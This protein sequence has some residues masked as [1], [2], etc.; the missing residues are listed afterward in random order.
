MPKLKKI[1]QRTPDLITDRQFRKDA[2]NRAANIVGVQTRKILHQAK[3]IIS[4][5]DLYTSKTISK[6]DRLINLHKFEAADKLLIEAIARYP[7]KDRVT[8]KTLFAWLA[9][10]HKRSLI[11]IKKRLDRTNEY[12][13]EITRYKES[14]NKRP[15]NSL[16]IALVTAI[17]GGYDSVKLPEIV[18]P[19]IDYYLFTD[20]TVRDV[21]VFK[22]R[23]LP[24]IDGDQTRT[25]RY[26]K[27]NA[28]R[29]L[30]E[31]DLIVWID[32]NIMILGDIY[33]FINRVI[34]NKCG[35]GG[36]RHPLRNNL[37]DEGKA[38]IKAKRG[39]IGAIKDQLEFYRSINYNSN[40]LLETGFMIYDTRQTAVRE[41]LNMW[42][43][44]IDTKSK[45]DQISVNYS[46]DKSEVKWCSV[47]ERPVTIRNHPAF[48]LTRHGINAAHHLLESNLEGNQ[49]NPV[50]TESYAQTKNEPIKGVSVDIIYCVYN[51]LDDVKICLTSVKKYIEPNQRLIIIDDGSDTATK[52]YLVRFVQKNKQWC[53]LNRSERPSGYT[54]AANRGLKLSNADFSILLNSD[55][56]V[57]KGW[58]NK[59]AR[60][61]FMNADVGIVGPLSSA[62]SQQSI[63]D[64]TNNLNQ[65]AT[66]SLPDGLT[67]DRMNDL[68][69]EISR[70]ELMPRVPLVHGFCFGIKKEVIEKIGYFDE[71]AFPRG[72][73]E[74]NDYCFRAANAGFGLMIATNTYVYHA[75]SKSYIG[76]ERVAL[77]N[78]GMRSLVTLHSQHRVTRAVKTMEV[79]PYLIR[80]RNAADQLY[81]SHS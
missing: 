77:M 59:M 14:A 58:A 61:A 68:C 78:A 35:V 43:N 67:P 56:I 9:F 72:Y 50:A 66:N 69:E 11:S 36:M 41:F 62:A 12:Q 48:A 7:K 71:I 39:D 1:V 65:T 33:P 32:A 37:F 49:F 6:V 34:E 46:L 51:A 13:T 45:R 73:G 17:S 8:Q 30:P 52:Q 42:W 26:V 25:A 22:I 38:C 31:Y 63:P 54:K 47:T 3:K 24:Y 60:V 21:G 27:T 28:H 18:D 44:E 23:P 75:K 74:E 4:K 2:T 70:T 19:R 55:T 53:T 15:K 10:S 76:P 80:M 79:N 64:S 57:T 81:K 20:T 16:K 5:T 40:D 29:I